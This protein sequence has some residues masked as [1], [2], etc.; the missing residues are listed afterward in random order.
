MISC[1]STA[2]LSSNRLFH[3]YSTRKHFPS[4]ITSG[5]G[6]QSYNKVHST[7]SPDL[8]IQ[9]TTLSNRKITGAELIRRKALE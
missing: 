3:V 1:R 4:H 2:P 7:A 6:Q 8:N 5:L 9:I